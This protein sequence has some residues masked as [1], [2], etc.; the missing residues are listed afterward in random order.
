VVDTTHLSETQVV[1]HIVGL[2]KKSLGN[3]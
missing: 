3:G 2:V 1:D